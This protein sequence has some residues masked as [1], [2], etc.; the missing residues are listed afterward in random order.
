MTKNEITAIKDIITN[1]LMKYKGFYFNRNIRR[2]L[3]VVEEYVEVI[4]DHIKKLQPEGY[5]KISEKI[6]EYNEK[7]E[8]I[9]KPIKDLEEEFNKLKENGTD[10]TLLEADYSNRFKA[11]NEET[12]KEIEPLKIEYK[13]E[14]EIFEAY[15]KEV[16]KFLSEEA[17]DIEFIKIKEENI[18]SVVLEG[19]GFNASIVLEEIMEEKK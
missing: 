11:L 2:N 16:E 9:I 15:N 17:D 6:K 13:K 1:D 8:K 3:K 18:P 5:D 4:Q 7:I 19:I 14:I 10:K 12:N